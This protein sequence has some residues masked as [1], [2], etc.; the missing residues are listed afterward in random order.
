MVVMDTQNHPIRAYCKLNGIR[1][2]EFADICGVSATFIS[3]LIH[4]RAGCGRQAALRIKR[5]TGITCDA[6]MEWGVKEGSGAET[7]SA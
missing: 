4:N 3:D 6:L 2:K 1:Q 7:A 5:H